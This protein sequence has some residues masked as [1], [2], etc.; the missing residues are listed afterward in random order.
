MAIWQIKNRDGSSRWRA[1]LMGTMGK[2]INVTFESRADAELWVAKVKQQRAQVKAEEGV[3]NRSAEI[4]ADLLMASQQGHTV[5]AI[6]KKAIELDW[7]DSLIGQKRGIRACR[8]VG[9][10]TPIN[11]V[12]TETLDEVVAALRSEGQSTATIKIYLSALSVVLKRARR[13]KAIYELPL[14]PEGRTLKRAEPRELVIQQDWF[15]YFLSRFECDSWHRLTEFIW[16]TGCRVSEAQKLP[17]ERINLSAGR[18]QF[19]KTKASM[20]RS[21]PISGDVERILLQCKRNR[22]DNG[23]FPKDY[24]SFREYYKERVAMTCNHFG[25]GEDI[26]EQW[27]IH[28]LRH[29][30]LTRLANAGANAIQIKEWAGHHSLSV[31]QRYIHSSGIDL[32]SLVSVERRQASLLK[33]IEGQF[34]V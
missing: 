13:L 19:V 3:R 5:G 1:R 18:I 24:S 7:P 9:F 20:P 26:Y 34:T 8:M 16:H 4:D 6:L 14:M 12:T 22:P 31:S 11:E 15:D 27:C 33:G 21:L 2:R 30:K 32:E 28:T 23:P 10:A 25:L 17:W 29:T